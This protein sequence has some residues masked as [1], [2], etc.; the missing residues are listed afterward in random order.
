MSFIQFWCNKHGITTLT[1]SGWKEPEIS[2][3]NDRVS[4]LSTKLTTKN[5]KNA[6]KTKDEV[7]TEKL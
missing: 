2:G 4:H 6:L 5:I 1:F 3:I 7:I